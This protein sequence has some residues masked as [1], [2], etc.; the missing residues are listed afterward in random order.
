MDLSVLWGSCNFLL[1]AY[2]SAIFFMSFI[3]PFEPLGVEN[4]SLN[5]PTQWLNV[6]VRFFYIPCCCERVR[7]VL[8]HPP[9]IPTRTP[10]EMHRF[11]SKFFD[12]MAPCFSPNIGPVLGR[13]H[14][15][16]LLGS[17]TVSKKQVECWP[18]SSHEVRWSPMSIDIS[19]IISDNDRSSSIIIMEPVG[20]FWVKITFS[21]PIWWAI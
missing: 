5:C 1:R 4:L 20:A 2:V 7:H 10:R 16:K 19:F 6:F 8:Q 17:R 13:F 21:T 15:G 11:E 9:L 12:I 18:C 14:G 3:A